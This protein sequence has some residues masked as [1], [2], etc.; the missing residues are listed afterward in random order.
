MLTRTHIT[1]FYN[2][3]KRRKKGNLNN[4]LIK[5]N[6]AP[7]I[8]AKDIN[9]NFD[10]THE[11]IKRERRRVGGPGIVD[12]F[13]LSA[14]LNSFTIKVGTGTIVNEKGEEVFVEGKTFAAGAPEF[15]PRKEKII[16]PF[17][18]II[19]ISERPYSD[20]KKGYIEY[21][22]DVSGINNLPTPE[23]FSIHCDAENLRVYCT[24]INEKTVYVNQPE[25]WLD[26]EL[27]FSYFTA[28]NRIDAILLYSDGT[29][30]YQK[31]IISDN[32]SHVE[33]KDYPD[34][35]MMIGVIHWVIGEKVQVEFYTNHRSYRNVYVNRKRQLFLNGKPYRESQMIYF[36]PPEYPQE[37]NI[38]YDSSTNSLM[39][40]RQKAG[41]WGWVLMNDFAHISIREHKLWT[42]QTFPADAQTFLFGDDEIN[43]KYVPGKNSLQVII[44]NCILMSDQYEEIVSK[45]HPNAPDYMAQ[46]IGFRLKDPLDRPTYVDLFVTHQ[47]RTQPVRETFQRAAIFIDENHEIKQAANTKQVFCT[48][49]PYVIG[50]KQLEVWVDGIRLAPGREFF[51]MTDENTLAQEEDKKKEKMSYYYKIT[52]PLNTGQYIEYRV[53]KHVWSYD[54]VS[55]LLDD[56][57]TEILNLKTGYESLRNDLS[58]TNDNV[59]HQLQSLSQ[60]IDRIQSTVQNSKVGLDRL[61]E[62]VKKRILGQKI[63]DVHMPAVALDIIKDASSED[64]IQLHLIS[65]IENRVLIKN[66]DYTLTPVTGGLRINLSQELTIPDNTIYVTGF[67]IGA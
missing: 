11:W 2:V 23:E 17:D 3:F 30:K 14:D 32:P 19:K 29:Y 63:F 41:I 27:T 42:P 60:T 49:Y 37:N 22:K 58:A 48:Q 7:G 4:E 46:G 52:K 28:D 62:E 65:Q 5:L 21:S 50:A 6:F 53:N 36:E 47:V 59:A 15:L 35:C 26:K 61:E 20:S 54:Q 24:Q 16:C 67:K 56:T 1:I 34:D 33:I 39:I 57:R 9:H 44:D 64:F 18:G 40:W 10:V 43:L 13:D 45:K 38:W 66:A 12:G 8:K 25:V 51:E 55:Q 31:S